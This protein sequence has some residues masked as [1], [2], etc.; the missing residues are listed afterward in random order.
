MSS[1]RVYY[2][3]GNVPHLGILGMY[4]LQHAHQQR[5]ESKHDRL[6]R[7]KQLHRPAMVDD[8]VTPQVPTICVFCLQ[9]RAPRKSGAS[10]LLLSALSLSL[11]HTS[12]ADC[13]PPLAC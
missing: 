12:V 6:H 5:A 7:L 10:N 13:L 9:R 4:A 11:S 2:S 1:E 3:V 8:T